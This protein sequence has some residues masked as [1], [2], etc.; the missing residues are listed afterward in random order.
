MME[1][2][3][4]N[5]KTIIRPLYVLFEGVADTCP[6]VMMQYDGRQYNIIY[7]SIYIYIYCNIGY[8]VGKM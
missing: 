2:H 6:S 5:D 8:I 3:K 1:E 4:K 7:I